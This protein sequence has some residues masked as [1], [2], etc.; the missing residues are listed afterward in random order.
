[1][2]DQQE[3]KLTDKQKLFV[4]EYLVDLN[5]SKAA[6]RAGYSEK[7]SRVIASELMDKPAVREAIQF[8]MD[9]RAKRTEIDADYVL[10]T[11]KKTIDRCAQEEPVMEWDPIAKKMVHTGEY[12][13]DASNV[14]KGSELLG[15]HLKLF[16]DTVKVD[17]TVKVETLSDAD[18]DRLIKEKEA[19]LSL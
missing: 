14:L 8:H 7:T 4:L 15:R 5:A 2:A 6:V 16:T 10:S 12:K 19:K 1:M 17:H 18:L 3:S 11:I 9:K 13:F